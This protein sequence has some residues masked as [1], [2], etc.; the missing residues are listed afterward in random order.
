[1]EY[2]AQK[3]LPSK[4]QDEVDIDIYINAGL[5]LDLPNLDAT[6]AKGIGLFRTEFQ[7]MVS[8]TLPKSKAQKEIYNQV[9]KSASG[10]PVIFRTLD[11][12]GDKVVPFLPRQKEENPALGLRAIRMALDRPSLLSYQVRALVGVSQGQDLKIM[13][14]MVTELS[15]FRA[16]KKIVN[17]ELARIKKMGQGLPKSVEVGCMLEVPA[18]AWQLPELLKEVDFL[19]IGTNDLMQFFFASDRTNPKLSNKYD[20]LSPA[21]LSLMKFIVS[22]A[23][24]AKVPVT[25][26]GEHGGNPLE[27][28][29][30]MGIGFKRFS[31]NPS[32]VGPIRMM[33]RKANI[34]K[35]ESFISPLLGSPKSSI[36]E[37]I[38]NFSKENL[39]PL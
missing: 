7:F 8:S 30:L 13:F 2:E 21:A 20:F 37:D 28:L 34:S 11:V 39:I 22:Q 10:R 19:S 32:A 9:F 17:Y 15:E 33:V 24:A 25:I 18:L 31:V 3:N 16:A 1:M 23:N 27:A 12:G 14:P 29:A 26:C 4:T 5:I 6:G 35:L 38:I 36:R